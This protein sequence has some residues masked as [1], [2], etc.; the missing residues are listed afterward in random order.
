M[1]Q[2]R[3][4]YHMK[5]GFIGL[6]IMGESMCERII[7]QGRHQ[8]IV[9]DVKK[10]LID[11]LVAVGA[12][13]ASSVAE[14]GGQ[15]SHIIV[16]VPN[17]EHVTAVVNELLPV[18]A[19]GT[20]IIDMSTISPAVSV[21]LAGK[22]AAAGSIMIDAPVVKS[23]AA[24]ISGDLGILVGG[25]EKTFE[26]VLPLLR[27]MGKNIIRMGNNG[28]GLAMKLCHNMLVAGI[29]NSVNEMLVLANSS[30]LSFDDTVKAVGYGGGQNFYLD[31]KAATLK[32]RDFSPKF[33]FLHMCKDLALAADLGR[34]RGVKL[35]A[36]QMVQN[37]YREGMEG[38]LGWE[39]FSAAL[40]VVEKQSISRK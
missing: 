2:T 10:S 14:V 27:C 22:V 19:K 24:A 26:A 7:T 17:S 8:T 18:I 5:V 3:T 21:S 9:Y 15:S 40:K 20:V 38:N 32:A 37:I 4:K 31:S 36:L 35:A 13:G 34:E 23:K 25:D 6:G 33:P 1:R 11:K 12:K 39:D 30:G 16:M 29:Q 28:A